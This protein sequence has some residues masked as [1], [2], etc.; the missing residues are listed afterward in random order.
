MTGVRYRIEFAPI[1]A[2][3]FRKLPADLRKR[4][5]PRID[6]LALQP[7]SPDAKKLQGMDDLY[8]IRAGDYRVVYQ[9]RDRVL[10][11]LVVKI[12]HRS[13]VYR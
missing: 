8:R 3:A 1:A 6:A 12:G 9:I 10:L 4:L 11:V 5:A 2:K 13:D 7:R